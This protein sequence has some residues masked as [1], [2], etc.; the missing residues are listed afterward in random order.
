MSPWLL[1]HTS[2]ASFLSPTL[3]WSSGETPQ[4]WR[5]FRKRMFL[6][7]SLVHKP[8]LEVWR[9]CELDIRLG[10]LQGFRNLLQGWG[11]AQELPRVACFSHTSGHICRV[12]SDSCYWSN[13]GWLVQCPWTLLQFLQCKP[14]QSATTWCSSMPCRT[15]GPSPLGWTRHGDRTAVQW[16]S[17]HRPARWAARASR[18]EPRQR[19]TRGAAEPNGSLALIINTNNSKVGDP[20]PC[21]IAQH[22]PLRTSR[23]CFYVSWMCVSTKICWI[24]FCKYHKHVFKL[25]GR[26]FAELALHSEE[27]SHLFSKQICKFTLFWQSTHLD[28]IHDFN[29]NT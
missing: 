23:A 8:I 10:C 3:W 9:P 20:S 15:W 12:A 29:L 7:S 21:I 25:V 17:R 22:S 2:K 11:P 26:E 27:H 4:T 14:G 1:V 5:H 19:R 18:H 13:Y 28:S 6:Y 16:A 24:I